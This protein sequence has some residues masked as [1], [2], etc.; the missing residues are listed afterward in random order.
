MAGKRQRGIKIIERAGI[1]YLRGTIRA[2]GESRSIRETTGLRASESKAWERAEAIRIKRE[3][4]LLDELIFGRRATITWTEA[5]ADYCERRR[6]KLILR[7]TLNAHRPDFIAQRL[8][9]IT[10]FFLRRWG[11]QDKPLHKIEQEDIDAYFR[12]NHRGQALSYQKTLASHYAAVMNRARRAGLVHTFPMPDLPETPSP[13]AQPVNKWLEAEEVRLLLEEAAPHVRPLLAVAFGAGRRTGELPYLKLN[14]LDLTPGQE[15]IF[16]GRTKNGEAQ[17]VYLSDWVADE[18]RAWLGSR[19]DD[20]DTIFLTDKGRP[21]KTRLYQGGGVIKTAFR[22]CKKRVAARL[23]AMGR[24]DRAA[25]V[26]KATP[27]WGRHTMASYLVAAGV[28]GVELDKT[29]GWKDG[30]MKQRYAHLDP[31]RQ[32]SIVNK[33]NFGSISA[34]KKK[35]SA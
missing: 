7:D 11:G 14:A 15:R 26:M 6:E 19:T 35:E 28:D 34:H 20:H 25:L 31:A 13:L 5:A 24:H 2:A 32:K 8:M 3:R 9:R 4:E 27:H 17:F 29:M 1:L 16:L 12:E 18:L 23:R 10:D 22:G 21:F 30:R 33:V